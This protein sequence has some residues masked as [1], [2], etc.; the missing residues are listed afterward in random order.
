MTVTPRLHL[1][2]SG[3]LQEDFDNGRDYYVLH[4]SSVRVPP[5]AA[6]R[7]SGEFLLWHN[8]NVYRG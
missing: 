4:G 6:A 7:P 1:E 3:R 5:K 2:V 8:E